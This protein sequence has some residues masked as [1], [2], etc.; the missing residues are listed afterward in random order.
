MQLKKDIASINKSENVF[1][2]A[3]KTNNLY[4]VKP[5]EYQKLLHNNITKTYKKAPQLIEQEINLE[6]KSIA[7]KMKLADRI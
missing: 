6:A 1:V 4:E 2:S 5:D 7:E 3:D